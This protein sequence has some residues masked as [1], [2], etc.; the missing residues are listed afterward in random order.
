MEKNE[1]RERERFKKKNRQEYTHREY[2]QG[3]LTYKL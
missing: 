2:I 3:M 1:K